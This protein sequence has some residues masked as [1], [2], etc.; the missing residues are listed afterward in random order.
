MRG[1]SGRGDHRVC[2]TRVRRNAIT[3]MATATPGHATAN[4]TPVVDTGG[5]TAVAADDRH[6]RERRHDDGRGLERVADAG[7]EH[8][9][10]EVSVGPTEIHRQRRRRGHR[11][12]AG[13]E[14]RSARSPRPPAGRGP[15]DEPL[16]DRGRRRP[17]A[18]AAMPM[19]AVGVARWRSMNGPSGSGRPRPMSG[20]SVS[21][22][23]PSVVSSAMAYAASA[24][25]AT[26]GVVPCHAA[27]AAAPATTA[28]VAMRATRAAGHR[29]AP[30]QSR[31][32]VARPVG[33]AGRRRNHGRARGASCA[34]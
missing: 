33:R 23:K 29:S 25:S 4:A 27:A 22:A 17:R 13:D 20:W 10:A 28:S 30:Y 6:E 19:I 18:L 12:E 24:H 9:D 3:P 16:R 26:N 32:H 2:Q 21:C 5:S 15:P 1:L 31:R 11:G 8:H 7:V 34:S 14:R